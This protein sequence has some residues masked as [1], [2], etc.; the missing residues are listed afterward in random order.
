VIRDEGHGFD[1]AMVPAVCRPS[2]LEA[3]QARG[4]ALIRSFMDEVTFNEVGNEITM[5]KRKDKRGQTAQ[6]VE[7]SFDG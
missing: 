7:D 3:E 5:I 6:R 2:D 1:V 4:L